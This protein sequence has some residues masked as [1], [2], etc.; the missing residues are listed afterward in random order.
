MDQE[1]APVDIKKQWQ[2]ARANRRMEFKVGNYRDGDKESNIRMLADWIFFSC[3]AGRVRDIVGSLLEFRCERKL[4][5]A[6]FPGSKQTTKQNTT[7]QH[8]HQTTAPPPGK[9]AKLGE[10]R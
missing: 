8:K 6:E 10:T 5:T 4:I 3:I 7:K 9:F 2:E 1:E